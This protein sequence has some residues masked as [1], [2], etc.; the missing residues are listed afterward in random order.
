MIGYFGVADLRRLFVAGIVTGIGGAI[1]ALLGLT[2]VRGAGGA[3][4]V[5]TIF[6]VV[7]PAFPLLSVRLG[8]VPMPAVPRDA[9]DLRANDVLPP[10]EQT[11]A[12]VAR[13]TELLTGA[14][15][16]TAAITVVGVAVLAG[17][18]TVSAV[19][20]A[21]IVSAAHLLRARMLVATRQRV[22]P[23]VSGIL[24]AVATVLGLTVMVPGWARFALIAPGLLLIAV[25]VCTAAMIFS[26]RAPSPYL[27][28]FADIGDVLLTLAAAPVAAQVLGL[29][30]VIR[31]M[32]G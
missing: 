11:V 22:A 13:S 12:R 17:T 7:S 19:L 18:R 16:G 14:L 32:A 23:L 5:V 24:G 28:R 8:K 30:H 27:G 25:L 9:E 6:L 20:L 29:Y 2:A 21:G 1:G 4:I 31:G 10:L 15:L 26:R 3:A